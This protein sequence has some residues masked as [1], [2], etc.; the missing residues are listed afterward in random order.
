MLYYQKLIARG[1]ITYKVGVN[2]LQ[3]DKGVGDRI[4]SRYSKL[5]DQKKQKDTSVGLRAE[6]RKGKCLNKDKGRCGK[7]RYLARAGCAA[8]PG[9]Q[10][11]T[12]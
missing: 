8:G 1:Q 9:G 3:R 4:F 12:R 5:M 2:I 6:G 7:W 11:M 10:A